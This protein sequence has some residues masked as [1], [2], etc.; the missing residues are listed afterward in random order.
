MA[1]KINHSTNQISSSGGEVMINSS[2]SLTVPIGTSANRPNMNQNG[3][4]RYNTTKGRF[5]FREDDSWNSYNTNIEYYVQGATIAPPV[6]QTG[7]IIMYTRTLTTSSNDVTVAITEDGTLDSDELFENLSQ[8][9]ISIN[10]I[11]DTSAD[12]QSPW[13]HIRSIATKTIRF[14][15]KRSNTGGILIGGSYQG[16]VNNTA[17][18]SMSINIVGL[19]K[20]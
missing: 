17:T 12:D 10:V 9:H 8:C 13:C 19:A 15:V 7:K 11:R 16:N 6:K 18:I 5:E 14:Q 4:I 2:G 1:I 20:T 3:Q